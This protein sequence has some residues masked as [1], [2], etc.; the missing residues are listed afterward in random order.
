MSQFSVGQSPG[1]L[2]LQAGIG[3]AV[4]CGTGLLGTSR[5][6][7]HLLCTTGSC[8]LCTFPGPGK[9]CGGCSNHRIGAGAEP[10]E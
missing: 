1:E 10:D 5:S 6:K 7:T 3:M 2:R 9:L 8:R 4:Q